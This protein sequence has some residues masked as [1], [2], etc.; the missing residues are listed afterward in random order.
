[1]G[2]IVTLTEKVLSSTLVQVAKDEDGIWGIPDDDFNNLDMMIIDYNLSSTLVA[3]S[4]VN[5]ELA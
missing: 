1:M 4:T 5:L 3:G 2:S